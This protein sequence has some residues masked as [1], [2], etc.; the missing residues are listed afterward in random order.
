[1]TEDFRD[2]YEGTSLGGTDLIAIFEQESFDFLTKYT[3]SWQSFNINRNVIAVFCAKATHGSEM[4]L[5]AVLLSKK[6][7]S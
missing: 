3:D 1:M 6:N 7:T 4:V 2:L 5:S